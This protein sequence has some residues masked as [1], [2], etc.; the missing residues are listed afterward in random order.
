[1]GKRREKRR[2]ELITI[3]KL[4]ASHCSS[5]ENSWFMH[6]CV[7]TG[8]L[9]AGED[10]VRDLPGRVLG[11]LLSDEELEVLCSHTQSLSEKIRDLPDRIRDVSQVCGREMSLEI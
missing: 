1:M 11:D 9:M 3:N 4:N 10:D 7:V 6:K 2:D 8:D 5:L